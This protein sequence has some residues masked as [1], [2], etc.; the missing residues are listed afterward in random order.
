MKCFLAMAGTV[1]VAILPIIQSASA[2]GGLASE[3]PWAPEHIERLPPDIRKA[4]L[5][6]ARA[7]GSKAAAAH[8]FSL[9]IESYGARFI[10]LHFEDFA[11]ANRAA[12]CNDNGCLHQ[13]HLKS[14]ERHRLVFITYADDVRLTNDGPTVGLEVLKRRR[15]QKFQWNGRHFTVSDVK[16]IWK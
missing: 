10:S 16:E 11:C 13:V 2:R 6:R 15:T 12:I 4:V 14:G 3:N 1:A 8:Y 5:R 7:C 9:S